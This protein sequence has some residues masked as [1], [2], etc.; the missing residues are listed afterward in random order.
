MKCIPKPT[1]SYSQKETE[2]LTMIE[3]SILRPASQL[4]DFY[5]EET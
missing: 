3:K 2:L 1:K 5:S 4:R